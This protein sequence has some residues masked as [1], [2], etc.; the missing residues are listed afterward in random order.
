MTKQYR[1]KIVGYGKEPIQRVEMVSETAQFLTYIDSSWNRP[2]E[3]REK[4][5]G[6]F[7]LTFEEARAEWEA[8]HRRKADAHRQRMEDALSRAGDAKALKNPYEEP[9]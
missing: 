6:K 3:L 8:E 5:E 7:F 4:K 2:H 9:A 1:Y